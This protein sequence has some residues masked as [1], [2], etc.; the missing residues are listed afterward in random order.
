MP[1]KNQVTLTFAGED[2]DLARTL[3]QAVAATEKMRRDVDKNN[4][5]MA[6]DADNTDIGERLARKMLGGIKDILTVGTK[7]IALTV[8]TAFSTQFLG[9][10]ASGL[11]SGVG[12]LAHGLASS[13]ALLPAVAVAAGTAMAVLKISL[14]GVGDALKAG[15]SGDTKAFD[16]A[17]KGLAP[18][19]QA[20]AR[21]IVGLKPA[22][23]SLKNTVQGNFFAPLVGEI[24]PLAAS[25]LPMLS[26]TLG[27]IASGFGL[28][29]RSTAEFLRLP[30]VSLSITAAM[31]DVRD[32]VINV[33]GA[34]PNL[35]TAFLPLIQVGASF[36]PGLSSGF[37][38]LTARLAIF[39]Q[40]AAGT[41]KLGDFIQGGLD[42]LRS[43]WDTLGKVVGILR[44]LGDIG[45]QIFGGMT[46]SSGG[47]LDTFANLLTR[48]QAFL[49][50]AQGAELLR[51]ALD[52]MN[53][54]AG[55]LFGTFQRVAGIVGKA[56]APVLPQILSFVEAFM[57][58][59]SAILDSGLDVLQPALNGLADG[60]GKVLPAA[61]GLT[62]WLAKTKPALAAVAAV[63]TTLMIPAL[64]TWTTKQYLA[65]LAQGKSIV[66]NAQQ[67]ASWA[68]SAASAV[69]SAALTAAAWA[70]SA[71]LS[72]ASFASTAASAAVSAGLTA[73]AWLESAAAWVAG[74][75][76]AAAST[77]VSA[78]TVVAGWVATGA[79]A[80]ANAAIT[81]AGWVAMAAGAVV[82]A[83]IIVAGWVAVGLAALVTGAQMAL[84]WLIGLGPIGLVIAAVIAII[85]I[86]AALGVN[87]DDVKRVAGIVWDFIR[88]A[89]VSA[90]NG[91]KDAV[92][93]AVG[94]VRSAFDSVVDWIGGIPGRVAGKL[95]GMWDGLKEGFVSVIDT[96]IGWWNRIGFTLPTIHIPKV[97]TPLGDIGGGSFGGQTFHVPQIPYLH[98]GG[99]FKA[100]SGRREGL[101]M[102]LDGETVNRPGSNPGGGENHYHFHIAG[103]VITQREL[104]RDIEDG[105]ATGRIRVA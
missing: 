76:T 73:A 20:A 44:Q 99:E 10:L 40:S 9:A 103:S 18:S 22:L 2:K 57:N 78:A 4:K 53:A 80:V 67:M 89:A 85:A 46:L 95:R 29:G 61:T 7:P 60:L 72:I 105:I 56:F 90:F 27:D 70:E 74:A 102:L 11:A 13:I 64:V 88:N 15:M 62:N 30:A 12:K 39:M 86:L 87:F 94:W 92:T 14:L 24:K 16:E 104:Y 58:L 84:A 37:S 45:S 101:A 50:T 35:V 52:A 54:I 28:A 36:L 8:A 41:G 100:P 91:V 5:A 75:A 59:K 49:N 93:G 68:S 32:A 23:D 6:K 83:A 47:L 38:D 81:V 97:S 55:N 21:E 34:L 79:A 66:A 82:N 19:A 17:L 77:A 98:T 42:K 69:T 51:A 65:I 48:F 63:I 31:R 71:A 33:T 43:L 26:S 25:Y 1:G 3:R 96:V